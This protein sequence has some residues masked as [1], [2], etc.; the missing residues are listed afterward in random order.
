MVATGPKQQP[1]TENNNLS[2]TSIPSPSKMDVDIDSEF[3]E[4]DV[5]LTL[6]RLRVKLINSSSKKLKKKL[7]LKLKAKLCHNTSVGNLVV[8]EKRSANNRNIKK[9][10]HRSKSVS[11][12][13]SEEKKILKKY[14]AT[15][16]S[17]Q[18]K[19]AAAAIQKCDVK[20]APRWLQIMYED[21]LITGRIYK[22][23]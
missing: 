20:N 6:N 21:D 2:S 9:G 23:F 17:Q 13:H 11:H 12:L 22:L 5:N 10:L 14:R 3:N 16:R 8:G 19:Q 18:A 15:K 7:S 1:N 4:S